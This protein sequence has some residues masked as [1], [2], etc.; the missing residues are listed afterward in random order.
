FLALVG[1]PPVGRAVVRVLRREHE[2][3]SA[4]GG[5]PGVAATGRA[6]GL[7]RADLD[8]PR[9]RPRHRPPPLLGWRPEHVG[10]ARQ[11]VLVYRGAAAGAL[12]HRGDPAASADPTPTG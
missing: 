2:R 7:F 10:A 6:G 8:L 9:R 3:L 4:D 5:R 1:G 12:D 11:H